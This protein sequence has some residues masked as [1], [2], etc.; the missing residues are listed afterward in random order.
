MNDKEIIEYYKGL[1]YEGFST[2]HTRDLL[3]KRGLT[4][5]DLIKMLIAYMHSG[6]NVNNITKNRSDEAK[7]NEVSKVALKYGIMKSKIG[8][9][10]ITL[11][12]LAASYLPVYYSLRS[13]LKDQ[14]VLE[15]PQIDIPK[16]RLVYADL[17]FMPFATK[18][19]EVKD[20]CVEFGMLISDSDKEDVKKDVENYALIG[21]DGIANDPKL[22][23]LDTIKS[24]KSDL[25][26][27]LAHFNLVPAKKT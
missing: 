18:Y 9:D 24:F 27:A 14:G 16:N 23:D 13:M 19:D 8:K 1:S 25:N 21:L 7:A 12:R 26:A 4:S 15:S 17:A 6:N 3:A 20:F 5:Q 11:F 10:S 2:E 22:I